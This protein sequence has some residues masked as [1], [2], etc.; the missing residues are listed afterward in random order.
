MRVGVGAGAGEALGV[1][2][3]R[4]APGAAAQGRY[5]GG[6][7]IGG[8]MAEDLKR[9]TISSGTVARVMLTAIAV[10]ALANLLWLGRD[11]IFAAILACLVGLYLSFWVDLLVERVGLKRGLAAP[12]VLLVSIA[13]LVGLFVLLWPTLKEQLG[14]VREQ[15]PRALER[16]SRW[17]RGVF[18][19]MGAEDVGQ[20]QSVEDQLRQRLRQEAGGIIGGALPLLNTLVGGIF[21]V[22]VIV[23]SGLFLAVDP[24]LYRR[25]FVRLLPRA[26][27]PRVNAA[28][29]EMAHALRGWMVGTGISMTIIGVGTTLGLWALGIPGFVALGVIAGLLQFI[30]NI[31]PLLSAVPAVALALMAEPSKVIWVLLLYAGIQLVETNAITPLIM[32]KIIDVPPALSLL[33]QALMAIVF[34]FFGLLLAVPILA[35]IIVLVDRLYDAEEMSEKRATG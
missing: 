15:L 21:G 32:K 13:V 34:G 23:A 11:A 14:T 4:R 30:P 8:G 26:H 16:V 2:G 27:R 28:L 19:S 10:F 12:L 33:F 22:F 1:E 3:T 18:S 29:G 7:D 9:I 25:G 20:A 24:D 5:G 31:G 6:G 35:A 17:A